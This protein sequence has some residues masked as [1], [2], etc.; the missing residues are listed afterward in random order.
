M[1]VRFA[2]HEAAPRHYRIG[3]I[4]A[5]VAVFHRVFHQGEQILLHGLGEFGLV[6]GYAPG[7]GQRH[8]RLGFAQMLE[9]KE[10]ASLGQDLALQSPTILLGRQQIG[11]RILL[12][13]VHPLLIGLG[14]GL[15]GE[16]NLRIQRP[17][18][19][20]LRI[21][22]PA[23][24]DGEGSAKLRLIQELNSLGHI[25]HFKSAGL[26]FGKA[27]QHHRRNHGR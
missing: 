6:Q 7:A 14:N 24:P 11:F 10:P 21:A 22:H 26:Q 17:H 8:A 5:A 16:L 18:V 25:R 4:P 23:P 15:Y 12:E 1:C 27:L 13:L 9:R 20:V 2:F 19:H 3:I